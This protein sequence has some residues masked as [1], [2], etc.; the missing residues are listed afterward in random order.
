MQKIFADRETI[1]ATEIEFQD[2][3]QK[4]INIFIGYFF[5]KDKKENEKFLNKINA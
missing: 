5:Y 3:D 1:G 4:Y 2:I